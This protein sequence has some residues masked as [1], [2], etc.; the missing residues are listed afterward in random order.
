MSALAATPIPSTGPPTVLPDFSGQAAV[1]NP[2]RGV[3]VSYQ[4]PFMALNP[5]SELHNDAWQT[6]TYR[7]AGPLGRSPR[8]FSTFIS[9]LCG[10][11]TFDSRGRLVSVCIGAAGPRLYMFDPKT[12]DVLAQF[13]LPPRAPLSPGTSLFQ[14]FS[15]GGYIFIDN[16]DRVWSA[17]TT[18]HLFVIAEQ[19]AT[20]GFT[21]E[22]DYDL[23][24]RL[25]PDEKI[26]SALPDS[27]GR[28]WFVAKRD[29]VVGTVDRRTGRIRIV[30]LGSG[31]ENEIENSFATGS[32]G[33]VYI[34][35][36]RAM[37]RFRADSKGRPRIVWRSRY[38]TSFV[39][40]PGQVDDG[41]GTTPTV[42]PDGY[43]AITDNAQPMN[44]VVYR[45]AAR[46]APGV[47]RK[48]CEVP[49][50][51]RLTGDTENSL[52]GAGRSLIV[53]NNYGYQDP[54]GPSAGALTT[55][56]FARVDV[57]RDGSGCRKVWTNTTERAPTVVPKLSLAT[58]LVY[59]YTRPPDPTGS[60]PWYWT[61]LDFRT[62]KR[63]WRQL[64]GTGQMYNNNYAGIAIGPDRTAY[65]GTLL[66]GIV[67]IRD[68]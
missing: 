31:T 5:R 42:L 13:E 9:R 41:T 58:G 40:K 17:T 60:Q 10:S 37:Y 28:I 2:I 50:F 54:F 57:L 61:A 64:A 46:L 45:T 53:E 65:L 33:A 15:G 62:G 7:G 3:P 49:V 68:G 4:N 20:P 24:R 14:D 63:V 55:P 27:T 44:V 52:I 48:V 39:K 38:R 67:A 66:G 59:T 6:D 30:R 19:G 11:I 25:L 43:V 8:T 51:G 21:L 29:G 1:R 35:T 36:N 16:R 12:L 34:A 18:R 56:G 22:R 26:T 47:Q 32:R 23:S